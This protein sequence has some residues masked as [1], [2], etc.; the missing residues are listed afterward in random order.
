MPSPAI[1]VVVFKASKD[2]LLA[3]CNINT[4]H[5]FSRKTNHLSAFRVVACYLC[6]SDFWIEIDRSDPVSYTLIEKFAD[7]L[8]L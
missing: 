3:I 8:Q 2:V 1:S 6:C 5:G 7:L 4:D